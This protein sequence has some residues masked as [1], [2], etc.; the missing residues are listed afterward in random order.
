MH[1]FLQYLLYLLQRGL[2]VAVP[3][4]LF[5]AASL[6]VTRGAFRANSPAPSPGKRLCVGANF[7]SG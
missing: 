1:D 7:I 5:C 6:A 3:T 2:W 4:V